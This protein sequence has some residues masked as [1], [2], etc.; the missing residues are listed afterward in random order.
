M[1]IRA[2]MSPFGADQDVGGRVEGIRAIARHPGLAKS[3]KL[4]I[5][6]ELHDGWPLPFFALPSDTQ[7]LSSRSTKNPR[8][9]N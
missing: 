4:S 3:S 2:K 5:G 6:T 9:G 8:A 1:S 7:T